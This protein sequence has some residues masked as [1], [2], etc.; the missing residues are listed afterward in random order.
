MQA[1]RTLRFWYYN[2]IQIIIHSGKLIA[3]MITFAII[4]FK[5]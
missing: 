5:T 1:I 2:L 4:T 3:L